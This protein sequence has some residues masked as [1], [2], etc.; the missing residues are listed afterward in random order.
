MANAAGAALYEHAFPGLQRAA[1]HHIG[2]D[3]A[4]HFRQAGGIDQRL[5]IRN[6]HA[7]AFG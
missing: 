6:C 4:E 5:V 7:L 3:R 2:P 1:I